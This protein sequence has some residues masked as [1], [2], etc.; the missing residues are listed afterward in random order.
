VLPHSIKG[1]PTLL[2][3]RHASPYQGC[4]HDACNAPKGDCKQPYDG[5]SIAQLQLF[6][7][8]HPTV[9][10]CPQMCVLLAHDIVTQPRSCSIPC[11]TTCPTHVKL[12]H[13]MPTQ[14]MRIYH[15]IYTREHVSKWMCVRQ[16]TFHIQLE[17]QLCDR[18]MIQKKHICVM[19]ARYL[20]FI[21][22]Y[23][24]R[25]INQT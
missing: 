9:L 8:A 21:H 7:D 17:P 14:A 3:H 6:H 2:I 16:Y 15:R 5:N 12:L 18:V 10:P 20:E 19:H 11:P 4:M 22:V 25:W 23:W 24:N 13:V 1:I